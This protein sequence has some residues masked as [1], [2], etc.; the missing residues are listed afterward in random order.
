MLAHRRRCLGFPKVYCDVTKRWLLVLNQNKHIT[1][2]IYQFRNQYWSSL[3]LS[4]H[5]LMAPI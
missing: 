5:R 4:P 2:Y 3:H 1:Y